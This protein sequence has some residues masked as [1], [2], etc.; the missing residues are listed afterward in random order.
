MAVKK[1][2]LKEGE[3]GEIMVA[4]VVYISKIGS[5]KIGTLTRTDSLLLNVC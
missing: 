2:I 1:K 4:C 3:E 5:T